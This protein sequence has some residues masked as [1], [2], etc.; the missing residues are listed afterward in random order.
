MLSYEPLKRTLKNKSIQIQE[1][2]E[3]SGVSRAT[4]SNM[5]NG[6]V[7]AKTD[8]IGKLCSALQ[9]NVS[10]I[11]EFK[12]GVAEPVTFINLNWDFLETHK[13]HF[14]FR[15]LS[16]EIGK[17]PSYLANCRSSNHSISSEDVKKLAALLNCS[18]MELIND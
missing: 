16:S 18:P 11:V 13:G 3:K 1:L 17:G 8:S 14:S 15:T 4:I 6:R 5:L 10:D 7:L 9:C 2:A 12:R